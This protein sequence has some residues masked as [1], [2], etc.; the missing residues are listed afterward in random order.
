MIK[1]SID[2][3]HLTTGTYL[4]TVQGEEPKFKFYKR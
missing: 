1:E 3:S 2:V 4:L